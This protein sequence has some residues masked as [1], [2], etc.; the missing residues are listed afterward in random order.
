MPDPA[1]ASSVQ[2]SNLRR[3]IARRV[4]DAHRGIDD[5]SLLA[6]VSGSVVEDI[7]DAK[8]DVDMSVVL[9]RL[10]N[11]ARLQAACVAGGGSDWVWQMGSLAEGGL[12][13]AFMVDGIEVQIAY[14]DWPSL[15]RDVDELLVRHNPDTPVHKLAE[16]LLKAEALAGA[17]EL[18]RLQQRLAQFPPELAD[19]MAR[20]WLATPTPWRAISQIVDR[21]TP[22]WCRE[23][24]V[25]CCY[26][27][28]GLLAAVNRCYFTRFQVKRLH[29]LADKF[30]RAPRQLA[31]RLEQLLGA[32][33]REAFAQ[34][35]VLEGEVMDIVAG[36]M[37]QV[38][39]GAL[40]ARRSA[41]TLGAA[42]AP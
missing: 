16:G 13:V 11:A 25:E 3:A 34:L 40:R 22:L 33:P 29:R 24:Q 4:A 15:N 30:E 37:P 39:L 2:R 14:A 38:D 32:A 23:L 8:S 42:A 20:H 6:L 19:A 7:A 31:D 5:A 28:L 36:A 41:S 21:D 1:P 12:V 35:F 17:A 10:P 9:A 18:A 26:R 27:L